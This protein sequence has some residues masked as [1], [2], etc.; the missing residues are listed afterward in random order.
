MYFDEVQHTE[1]T[2]AHITY[3]VQHYGL[4]SR[5]P[6]P[7]LP[8]SSSD[9]R[10]YDSPSHI[11]NTTAKPHAVVAQISP[12]HAQTPKTKMAK[13]VTAVAVVVVAP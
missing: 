11:R 3:N 13:I 5:T 6:T 10:S 8:Y 4:N 7:V 2:R 1:R 9:T 12:P